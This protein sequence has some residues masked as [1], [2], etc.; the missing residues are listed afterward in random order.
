MTTL[1][2][3]NIF[4]DLADFNKDAQTETPQLGMIQVNVSFEY[5]GICYPFSL[6]VGDTFDAGVVDSAL[7]VNKDEDVF[8]EFVKAVADETRLGYSDAE[9]FVSEFFKTLIVERN[10]QDLFDSYVKENYL[11]QEYWGLDAN[12]LSN[13]LERQL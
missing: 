2:I 11:T 5:N 13:Q 6:Q 9:E 4:I 12:S 7:E 10:I 3:Q 8:D 1:S